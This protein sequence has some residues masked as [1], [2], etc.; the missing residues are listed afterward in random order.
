LPL[1]SSLLFPS[2]S[3]WFSSLLPDTHY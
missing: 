3:L 2:L 1:F